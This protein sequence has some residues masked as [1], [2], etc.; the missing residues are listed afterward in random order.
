LEVFQEKV[1]TV[2]LENNADVDEWKFYEF[3]INIP[4]DME[5]RFELNI[6][7]PGTFWI[8]DIQIS[9]T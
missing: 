2:I 1:I 8:D 3:S 4:K 5:L 9:K 6:L 7:G